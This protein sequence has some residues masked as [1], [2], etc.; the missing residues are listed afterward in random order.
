MRASRR[1]VEAGAATLETSAMVAIAAVLVVALVGV[2]SPR[3]ARA[4]GSRTSGGVQRSHAVGV[5]GPVLVESW[6][7][8]GGRAPGRWCG[9]QWPHPAGG[10]HGPGPD[11]AALLPGAA[12]GVS[13]I[14]RAHV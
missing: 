3:R 2:F 8:R 4:V 10:R 1:V 5:C 7:A 13:K 12:T 11:G 9:H 14:G 6:R